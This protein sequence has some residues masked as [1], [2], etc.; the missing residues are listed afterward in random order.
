[1][2]FQSPLDW[3]HGWRRTPVADRRNGRFDVTLT[4]V[5]AAERVATQVRLLGFAERSLIISSNLRFAG[6]SLPSSVDPGVAVFWRD[7]R[8]TSCMA[9]DTYSTVAANLAAVAATLS[10]MRA[11]ER[12]GGGEVRNKAFAGFAALPAPEQPWQVLGLPT[13]SATPEQIED[14]YRRLA[15]R[16][17]PDRGGSAEAMAR[18]NAART[19]LLEH[20]L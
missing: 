9:I 19:A 3:P 13:N 15:M 1:M 18:I 16:H 20:L 8:A 17:H 10:A 7:K 5:E 12:H 4:S 2:K 6:E 14:A 11:I